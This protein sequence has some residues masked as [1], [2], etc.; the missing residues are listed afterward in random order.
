MPIYKSCPPYP[1]AH[2]RGRSR[3]LASVGT[4]A[5]VSTALRASSESGPMT[6]SVAS[7]SLPDKA[8]MISAIAADVRLKDSDVRVA[9]ALLFKFHNT[10][11]GKCFPS[12]E[13]IAQ[14]AGC[15]RRTAI[16]AVERLERDRVACSCFRTC[17]IFK[18]LR[19]SHSG[20]SRVTGELRPLMTRQT[21]L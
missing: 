5:W 9:V 3:C 20:D 8:V 21:P 1:T 6:N 18:S 7:I 19:L 12:Y 10:K 15:G 13:T 14:A 2:E 4:R 16:R 11:Q 17:G